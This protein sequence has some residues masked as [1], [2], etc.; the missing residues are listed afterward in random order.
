M[1]LRRLLA[2]GTL[3]IGLLAVACGGGDTNVTVNQ[4]QQTGIAV[5]GSGKVTVTPDIAVLNIGI[6]AT[7]TT[8]AEAREEAAR[9]AEA[10]RA[11]LIGNGV[12]ARDI[13]TRSF[14]IYPQY[15]RPRPC[16][17]PVAAP[18]R[19]VEPTLAPAPEPE[20]GAAADLPPRASPAIAT[21]DAP[22]PE[23]DAVTPSAT[24]GAATATA[25]EVQAECPA[26]PPQITGFTVSNQLIVKIRDACEGAAGVCS[27]SAVVD[28]ATEAAGD[29]VRVNSVSFTI[30]EPGRFFEEARRKAMDDAHERAEQLAELA[31]VKLGKVRSISEA[32]RAVPFPMPT[33]Q[34]AR[35]D[36]IAASATQFSPGEQEIVLT[37]SVLY[38]I[39]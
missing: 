30:D 32:G 31:G 5:T 10:L 18:E 13:A 15:S 29:L 6:E 20:P 7:R 1:N 2:G 9:A 17:A 4:P 12:A 8:V 21:V 14:N 23:P 27:L 3:A 37:V 33:V 24:E 39:E 22:A 19:E 34:F 38:D 16:L 26:Q 28:D 25:V 36:E 35:D 11:S